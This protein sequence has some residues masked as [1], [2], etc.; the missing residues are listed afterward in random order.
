[1]AK[2][3]TLYTTCILCLL[4]L[5]GCRETSTKPEDSASMSD[6]G[7][8][9]ADSSISETSENE[10]YYLESYAHARFVLFREGIMDATHIFIGECTSSYAKGIYSYAEF[11]PIEIIKGEITEELVPMR[12]FL[13]QRVYV[14]TLGNSYIEDLREYTAGEKYLI[15]ADKNMSVYTDRDYYSS[16]SAI[17]IPTDWSLRPPSMQGAHLRYSVEDDLDVF[18]GYDTVL[19]YVKDIVANNPYQ[20]TGGGTDYIRSEKL[21]D[22]T[23]QTDFILKA[24]LIDSFAIG[25]NRDREWC[26]F[27]VTEVL[28]GESVADEIQAVIPLNEVELNQEYILFLS[29]VN[30]TSTFYIISSK[31]SVYPTTDTETVEKIESLLQ[32]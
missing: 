21:E 31:N 20:P 14:D 9:E 27:S 15:I 11:K 18:A 12:S 13:Y 1:M 10:V 4:L 23:A 29:R 19:A 16:Q 17:F 3:F 25:S 28:K 30:P 7:I 5:V 8:T 2:K 32:P 22:I 24:T 6:T 26:T